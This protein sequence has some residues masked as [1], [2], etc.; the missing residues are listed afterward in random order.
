M[1]K[2]D[3]NKAVLL[4]R[5]AETLIKKKSLQ[6]KS[7]LQEAEA[8][9]LIHELQVHQV[10]LEIQNQELIEAKS[11]SEVAREK[12]TELYDFAPS[13]YFTLSREGDIKEINLCAAQMLGKERKYLKNSRFGFFISDET[14]P[15][16]NNFLD[17]VFKSHSR[18]I[19]EVTLSVNG[20]VSVMVQLTGKIS[21]NKNQCLISAVEITEQKLA[22]EEIQNNEIHYRMLLELAT[23]AFFQ[24]NING[25]FITVNS[26]AI[27]QTGFSRDELLKMNMKDLFSDEILSVQPLQYEKLR[28]GEVVN[29]ERDLIR[30]D[31][32]TITVEMKS[33]MMPDGTFQSF[34][35]DIT[36]RKQS[37]KELKR[38]LNE[39]GI[40]YELAI[41]RERKMIALKSEINMLLSR[42]GEELKY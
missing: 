37:D 17:K 29:N 19:C 10:E 35:R 5:M 33:R 18:E 32:T 27:E 28:S 1:K 2:V 6:E 12:Y 20:K 15:I 40:Y 14:K 38:K 30:K 4:R 36:E 16:F 7:Q 3:E 31:G 13:G 23:D 25:D 11:E 39:L 34:F 21:D 41:T 9:A 24:G 26:V 22:Q 42:L 8:M